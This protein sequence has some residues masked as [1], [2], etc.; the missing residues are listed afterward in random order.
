MT[1]RMKALVIGLACCAGTAGAQTPSRVGLSVQVPALTPSVQTHDTA[2]V[3]PVLRSSAVGVQSLHARTL[4]LDP[5]G[6]LAARPS[7][8][9]SRAMMIVGGGALLVGAIIGGDPGT[10]I[11]VGGVVVGLIGLYNY[12]Q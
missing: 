12:L 1:G 4:P 7:R 9:Q 11:M 6:A 8:D 2:S 3:G 10:V 5:S